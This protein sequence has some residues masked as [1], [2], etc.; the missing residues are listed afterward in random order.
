MTN[1]RLYRKG[2]GMSQK[3]VG[4]YLGITSQAYSNYETGKRQADYE[5]L[6]K[7]SKLFGASVEQML[8]NKNAPTKAETFSDELIAFYGGVK[9]ELTEDDIADIKDFIAF[10]AEHKRRKS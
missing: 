4:D 2:K 1:F 10:K 7:L 3:E 8:G 5:T 6:L 9:D